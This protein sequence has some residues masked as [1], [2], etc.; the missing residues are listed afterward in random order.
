MTIGINYNIAKFPK[1]N[2]PDREKMRLL[3]QDVEKIFPN[4]IS[5]VREGY[6]SVNYIEL[7]PLLIQAIKEQQLEI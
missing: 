1:R 2:F 5:T 7:T 6:K 4:I 3:A